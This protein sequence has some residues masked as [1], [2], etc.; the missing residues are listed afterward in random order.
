[1]PIYLHICKD[2]LH[3]IFYIYICIWHGCM[4]VCVFIYTTIQKYY[5]SSV[6]CVML[7]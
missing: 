7:Y 6:A 2:M 5:A 3:V 4:Y 1:M